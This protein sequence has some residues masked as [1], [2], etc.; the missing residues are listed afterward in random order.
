MG[1]ERGDN[2]VCKLFEGYNGVSNHTIPPCDLR[3]RS[4]DYAPTGLIGWHYLSNATCLIN[5]ASLVFHGLACLIR[6]CTGSA[7][8]EGVQGR[9]LSLP[10]L[11][12]AR[13]RGREAP[14]M[15][16]R[17]AKT[18]IILSYAK[19]CPAILQQALLSSP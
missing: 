14:S 8:L 4:P 7:V 5:A 12:D 19:V 6:L 18:H 3:S 9:V 1:L 15:T 17:C 2:E 10:N 16:Y 13:V 11:G